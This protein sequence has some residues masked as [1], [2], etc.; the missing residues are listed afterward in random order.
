LQVAMM[1]KV[2][3]D[4]YAYTTWDFLVAHLLQRHASLRSKSNSKQN[5]KLALET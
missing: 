5:F 1:E 3:T 4:R 2:K